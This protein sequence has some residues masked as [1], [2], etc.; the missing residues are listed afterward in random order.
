MRYIIVLV[1][2]FL[3]SGC[4]MLEPTL[5]QD[6]NGTGV[7]EKLDTNETIIEKSIV[8]ELA[9]SKKIES[10]DLGSG[11]ILV[12]V[13]DDELYFEK[14]KVQ[15]NKRKVVIKYLDAYSWEKRALNKIYRKHKRIWSKKQSKDFRKVLEEDKY[16][17]LCGD[18]RYWD[19]LEFQESEPERDVLH[20][21]LLIKYLNNLSHGCSRWVE[22]NGKINNENRKEYINTNYIFSLLPHDVLVKKLL[23]MYSPK[24]KGFSSLLKR[25]KASL[26]S[27]KKAEELKLERLKIE[28]YKRLEIH[29]NYKK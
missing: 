23:L 3:F 1:F 25:H 27:D 10:K 11:H 20:S 24:E 14:D 12:N 4:V 16:F 28:K 13:F 2:L 21:I 29:P 19:N 18:R 26:V 17:S 15:K 8:L 5:S 22:S 9:K 6:T 7:I